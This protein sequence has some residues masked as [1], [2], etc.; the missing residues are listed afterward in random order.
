MNVKLRNMTSIYFIDE[1]R[2]L[3]LYRM[4]SRV[5]GNSYIGSAG[6]HFEKEELNDAKACVLRELNEELGLTED[7]VDNLSLRYV[8]LRLKDGEIRQNYYYFASLKDKSR[9]LQSNEGQLEWIDFNDTAALEMP[10]TAK[11]VVEHYIRE[12]KDTDVLY[13]GVTT[14]TGVTFIE[15]KDF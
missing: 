13:A 9:Q 5:V 12:G 7:D 4:G 6:G 8:T 3:F 11:Y 10:F 2:M 1:N 15:L 14:E